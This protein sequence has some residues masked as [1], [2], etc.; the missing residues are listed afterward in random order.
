M[1]RNMQRIY[2]TAMQHSLPDV[3]DFHTGVVDSDS[4]AIKVRRR[5][6]WLTLCACADLQKRGQLHHILQSTWPRLILQQLV[7]A[8]FVRQRLL[9]R[10][11]I[12]GLARDNGSCDVVPVP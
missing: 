3:E 7:V 12:L 9:Q 8:H 6:V 5:L 1:T 4:G 10:V 2:D 11:C